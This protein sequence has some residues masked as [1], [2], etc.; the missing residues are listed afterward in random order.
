MSKKKE[1]D[2]VLDV[3]KSLLE[4]IRADYHK[5]VNGNKS[6]V[7]RMRKAETNLSKQA[8]EVRAFLLE[9]LKTM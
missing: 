7:A 4:G 8:K 9:H 5:M 3:Q 2:E 1:I 6:A